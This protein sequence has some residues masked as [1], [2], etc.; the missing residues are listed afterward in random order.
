MRRVE[1]VQAIC[2]LCR[3]VRPLA[4]N[5]TTCDACRFGLEH[6]L[7]Y[8][9]ERCHGTQPI[10]H[11]MY[12]YQL[13]GPGAFGAVSW[14]CHVGCGEYTCWRVVPEDVP[15]VPPADAPPSWGQQGAWLAQVR[16]QRQREQREA[17]GADEAAPAP[18]GPHGAAERGAEHGDAQ[19]GADCTMM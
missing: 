18:A 10:P 7:R 19:A 3:Q 1:R 5:A 17:E 12:R 8:E 14:A 15:R 2:Q 13:D 11:P 4:A 6:R 16:E 9:C